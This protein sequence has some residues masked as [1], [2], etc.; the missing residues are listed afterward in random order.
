[1]TALF[2]AFVTKLAKAQTSPEAFIKQATAGAMIR[3][4]LAGKEKEI[5]GVLFLDAKHRL[6]S[7]EK[8]FTGTVDSASFTL[9]KWLS[10]LSS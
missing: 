7:F 2:R 8:L 4:A 3:L 1:M 6:I 9:G 10:A 5:F